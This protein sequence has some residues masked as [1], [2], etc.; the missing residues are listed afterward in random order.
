MTKKKKL[1]LKD[2]IKLMTD[3]HGVDYLTARNVLRGKREISE[4]EIQ[5][6]MQKR[7]R[8]RVS[9]LPQVRIKTGENADSE[10]LR[11]QSRSRQK[12]CVDPYHETREFVSGLDI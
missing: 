11:R 4:S 8:A 12:Y 1:A 9:P 7:D 3:V 6:L 2:A 10:K 5:L